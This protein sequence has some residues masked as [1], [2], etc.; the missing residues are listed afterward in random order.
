VDAEGDGVHEDEEGR[1]GGLGAEG[2][3]CDGIG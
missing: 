3:V 1:E 2:G